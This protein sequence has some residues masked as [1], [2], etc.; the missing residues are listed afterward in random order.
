MEKQNVIGSGCYAKPERL[1]RIFKKL[2]RAY[3]LG[4]FK[5]SQL[6]DGFASKEI[7]GADLLQK[8]IA[9]EKSDIGSRGCGGYNYKAFYKITGFYLMLNDQGLNLSIFARSNSRRP[10]I[11]TTRLDGLTKLRQKRLH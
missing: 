6:F 3:T 10:E 8:L 5:G 7:Q 2:V 1:S 4:P 9:G 11:V